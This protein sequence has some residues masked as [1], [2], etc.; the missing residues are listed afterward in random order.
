MNRQSSITKPIFLIFN[1]LPQQKKG[2]QKASLELELLLSNYFCQDDHCSSQYRGVEKCTSRDSDSG[3][4]FRLAN[5]GAVASDLEML[6]Q[7]TL[8]TSTFAFGIAR[9]AH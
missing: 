8:G 3:E 7:E 5:G 2:W 9:I 4:P 1:F 6:H